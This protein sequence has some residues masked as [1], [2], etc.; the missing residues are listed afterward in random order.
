MHQFIIAPLHCPVCGKISDDTLRDRVLQPWDCPS[1]G[2]RGLWAV[3][4]FIAEGAEDWLTGGDDGAISDA[5]V[6]ASRAGRNSAKLP[7]LD[8]AR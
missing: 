2:T 4:T 3:L 7:A 8:R 5:C 6:P 1:C